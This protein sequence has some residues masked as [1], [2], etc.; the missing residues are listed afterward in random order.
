MTDPANKTICP[1]C[2]SEAKLLDRTGE[3]T[4][5]D[6]PEHGRFKVSGTILAIPAK[7]GVSRERWQAALR[8]AKQRDPTA[9]ATLITSYDFD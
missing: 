5:Y 8:R 2:K 7:R 1:I 6:C 4:G 9:W 3:A